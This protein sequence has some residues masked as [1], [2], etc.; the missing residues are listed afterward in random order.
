MARTPAGQVNERQEILMRSALLPAAVI[1]LLGLLVDV[2]P[3]AAQYPQAAPPPQA[4]PFLPPQPFVPPQA[5]P[6]VREAP[7]PAQARSAA[8]RARARTARARTASR[9][10]RPSHKRRHAVHQLPDQRK[11]AEDQRKIAETDGYKQLSDLV[12]F[13]NFFP[14][15]GIILVKPDTLPTGPFLCFD[16]SDRLVATVYM[17]SIKDIDDHK[18]F[19]AQAP[20]FAGKVDHVTHYFNPGHPGM[21][22]PHYHIV[23]WHVSK[24]EEARVAH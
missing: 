21:D 5:E 17:V 22:M 8:R 20:A 11:I 9:S 23:L 4:Q 15:L 19:E 10:E 3:T 24:A 13:P 1:V 18:S 16:R 2:R 6:T 12:N 14:G 7:V